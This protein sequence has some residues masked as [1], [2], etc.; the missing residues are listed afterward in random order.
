MQIDNLTCVLVTDGRKTLYFRNE[1]DARFPNL[2]TVRSWQDDNPADRGQKSDSPGRS[3]GSERS[4]RRSGYQEADFHQL[5]EDR[6]AARTAE[7]LN[8]EA[9]RGAFSELIVVAPPRTLGELR[10]HYHKEVSR[11]LAGEFPR[12]L[13]KHPIP[14]IERLISRA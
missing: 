10:R 8:G 7:F 3:L 2:K 14:E 12:D 5:A 11:R 4:G 6:F 1:G 13:V 9:M